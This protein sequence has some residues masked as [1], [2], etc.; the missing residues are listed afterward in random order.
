M[1]LGLLE[2]LEHGP[3]A[4]HKLAADRGYHADSVARLL[5][6]C[7]TLGVLHEVEARFRLE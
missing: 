1:R 4:A 3:S 5:R 2:G 7:V 6:G